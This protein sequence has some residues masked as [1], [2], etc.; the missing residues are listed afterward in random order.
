[1][2]QTARLL[3]ATGSYWRDA[4]KDGEGWDA[5][6]QPCKRPAGRDAKECAVTA[7]AAWLGQRGCAG[8]GAKTVVEGVRYKGGSSVVCLVAIVG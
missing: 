4:V 1:M 6:W 3:K 2:R 8:R 5:A 7:R